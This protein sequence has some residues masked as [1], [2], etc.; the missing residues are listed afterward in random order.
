[1]KTKWLCSRY[2]QLN[3]VEKKN[4]GISIM[5]SAIKKLNAQ[6]YNKK[7]KPISFNKGDSV[8]KKI[9]PFMKDPPQKV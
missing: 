1:M 5:D 9:L 4:L 8:L 3:F 7:V 6:A 2:E